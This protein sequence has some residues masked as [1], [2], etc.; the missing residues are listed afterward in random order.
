MKFLRLQVPLFYLASILLAALMQCAPVAAAQPLA[1]HEE[2]RSAVQD[3]SVHGH[4]VHGHSA[5]VEEQTP[6]SCP[7]DEATCLCDRTVEASFEP[8]LKLR[9][10]PAPHAVIQ[11]QWQ[12]PDLVAEIRTLPHADPPERQGRHKQAYADAFHRTGRL[13]I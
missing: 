2:H 4:S 1:V 10:L 7:G 5:P 13:L 8:S 3:H 9:G 12:M 11:T 6:P